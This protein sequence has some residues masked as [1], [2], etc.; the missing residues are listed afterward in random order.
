M[1]ILNFSHPLTPAHLAQ[2]E[3]LAGQAVERVVVVNSQIDTER[4][5]APQVAAMADACGLSAEEWQTLPLL[6]VPPALNFSAAALLAELHG[7][8]GYFPAHLRLR[9]VQGGL[10]PRYEVAEVL[11]LQAVRDTARRW[12]GKE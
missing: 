12:R 6:V 3:A 10:P 9:P 5:L 7:R 8:C 2:V 4:P 11:N 1:L